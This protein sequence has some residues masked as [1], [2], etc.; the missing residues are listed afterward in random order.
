MGMVPAVRTSLRR[1]ERKAEGKEKERRGKGKA[2][3]R[4]KEKR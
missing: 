2:E 4:E 1:G 3:E